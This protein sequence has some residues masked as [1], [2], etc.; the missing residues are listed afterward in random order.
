VTH[1]PSH[2]SCH[3]R[4]W[5]AS[6]NACCP[7][8]SWPTPEAIILGKFVPQKR[9]SAS[10]PLPSRCRFGHPPQHTGRN[11]HREQVA[12][13][14]G[15]NVAH[16]LRSGNSLS[17]RS[18]SGSSGRSGRPRG[19]APRPAARTCIP[20]RLRRRPPSHRLEHH[21]LMCGGAAARQPCPGRP[22]PGRAAAAGRSAAVDP[23]HCQMV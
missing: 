3:G 17:V 14:V 23:F 9:P 5:S 10:V 21:R 15:S 22:G 13:L 19:A 11:E 12:W 1:R 7:A 2:E 8:S 18:T 6:L 16:Q 20:V 4:N